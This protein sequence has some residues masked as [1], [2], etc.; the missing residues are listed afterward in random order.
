MFCQGIKPMSRS[1]SNVVVIGAGS[2]APVSG[3]ASAS[4]WTETMTE[5][6]VA[7]HIEGLRRKLPA[8]S[9]VTTQ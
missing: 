4:E 3:I 7:G 5:R 8:L 1:R 9:I 6:A 2:Y